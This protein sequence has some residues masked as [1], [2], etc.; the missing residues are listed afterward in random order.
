MSCTAT[1]L[2]CICAKMLTTSHGL[3][4]LGASKPRPKPTFRPLLRH[5]TPSRPWAFRH[6]LCPCPPPPTLSDQD[7]YLFLSSEW[8]VPDFQRRHGKAGRP[9]R[10]SGYV[11]LRAAGR[12]YNGFAYRRAQFPKHVPLSRQSL[13]RLY[14][15]FRRSR[16]V[17]SSHWHQSSSPRQCESLC[18]SRALWSR[19][20]SRDPAGG[21]HCTG[22]LRTMLI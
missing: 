21:C 12:A 1:D 4:A 18:P 10:M 14:S 8:C 19:C 5:F 22:I 15:H 3:R 17:E 6:L 11:G 2:V 16:L 20:G 9:A 13:L 7:P